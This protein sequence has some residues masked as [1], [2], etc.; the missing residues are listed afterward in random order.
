MAA[1][2]PVLV[3]NVDAFVELPE[4][5]CVKVDVGPTEEAQIETLLRAL[6]L[7]DELRRQ[8]GANA[9]AYIRQ[10]CNPAIVAHHY[11]DFICALL[12]GTKRPDT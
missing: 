1:A 8:I 2:K 9:A 10:E 6:M 5:A 12:E 11:I 4:M 7:D 3:S